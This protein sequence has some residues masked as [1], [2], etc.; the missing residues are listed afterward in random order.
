MA[1]R[2]IRG[3]DS[4]VFDDKSGFSCCF[5]VESGDEYGQAIVFESIN[6]VSN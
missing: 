6:Y 2:K 4:S 5:S 1:R 3:V